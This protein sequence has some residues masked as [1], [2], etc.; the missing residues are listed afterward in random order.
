MNK[1]SYVVYK[2]GM[3]ERFGYTAVHAIID[4]SL[5]VAIIAGLLTLVL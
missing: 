2:L 5:L 4:F 1:F 3:M